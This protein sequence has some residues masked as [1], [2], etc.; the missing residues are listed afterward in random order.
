M[1]AKDWCYSFSSHRTGH[2]RDQAHRRQRKWKLIERWKMEELVLLLPS[3]MHLSLLLFAVGLCLYLWDLNHTTAI[4]VMYTLQRFAKTPEDVAKRCNSAGDASFDLALTLVDS[5]FQLCSM[6][7]SWVGGRIKSLEL[8]EDLTTSLALSW[9]IQHCENPSAVDIALQAIAGASQGIPKPPLLSCQATDQIIRRIVSHS[10]D[11]KE[12]P[13]N[14]L[15]TRGLAFLGLKSGLNPIEGKQRAAGDI[16]VMV[17][18]LKSKNESIIAKLIQDGSF[19]PTDDNLEAMRIGNSAASQSLRF[20]RGEATTS[21]KNLHSISQLLSRHFESKGKQLHP[22]AVQSLANAAALYLS[23]STC[24]EL[25]PD[26][27]RLCMRY[28][29]QLIREQ[30]GDGTTE[31]VYKFGAGVVFIICVLLHI[32]PNAGDLLDTPHSVS[33]LSIR[34]LHA[35]RALIKVNMEGTSFQESIFWIGCSEIVFDPSEYGLDEETDYWRSVEGWCS[36]RASNFMLEWGDPFIPKW[37]GNYE[38]SKLNH[39]EF[40]DSISLVHELVSVSR[41]RGSMPTQLPESIHTILVMIACDSSLDSPHRQVCDELVSKF[42]FPALSKAL[43][44]SLE[45]PTNYENQTVISKIGAC[46]T[47]RR[48]AQGRRHFAATQLWLLLNLADG[49]SPPDDQLTL[50]ENIKRELE[51][52]PAGYRKEPRVNEEVAND[53]GESLSFWE[54]IKAQGSCALQ[55]GD[56]DSPKGKHQRV[57]TARIIERILEVRGMQDD[58]DLLD[59]IK[60]DLEGTASHLREPLSRLPPL[61][62]ASRYPAQTGA[63]SGPEKAVD[64]YANGPEYVSLDV[65]DMPASEASDAEDNYSDCGSDTPF[66]DPSKS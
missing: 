1:L 6:I 23:L 27:M 34:A 60:T 38:T 19:I 18:D 20:L 43:I 52:Q 45:L 10:T 31:S 61:R 46:Y 16:E 39:N 29:I 32:H 25:P 53:K 26:L 8:T 41:L 50:K 5:P 22:A 30:S 24:P 21:I 47:K 14:D 62:A 9:I 28:C 64:L 58:S 33:Q 56:E 63:K 40:L 17:W 11:D 15:Y 48:Q 55:T 66:N 3:L 49:S 57:Y 13:T 12:K 4:P 7:H 37:H 51:R 42:S 44:T 59:L 54:R 35:I 36:Q 65:R 2:P